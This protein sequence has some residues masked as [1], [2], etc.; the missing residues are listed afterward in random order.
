M[1]F[2]NIKSSLI[3]ACACLSLSV[4][5]SAALPPPPTA[6]GV[7]QT[8]D[9]AWSGGI[10]NT[11]SATG[12]I[13]LD[14]GWFT[15]GGHSVLLPST[16]VP[17]LSLTVSG[18]SAGNGT[19]GIAD[20]TIILL[21]LTPP[22]SSLTTNLVGQAGFTNF[23]LY[24][25]TNGVPYT[26]GAFQLTT[27]YNVA[28][29]AMSLTTFILHVDPPAAVAAG[30][31]AETAPV[32]FV[33]DIGSIGSAI[34]SSTPTALGLR[35]SSFNTSRTGISVFGQRLNRLRNIQDG[36]SNTI[37]F[38]ERSNNTS[39]AQDGTS[40]TIVVGEGDGPEVSKKSS[41]STK[42]VLP[43]SVNIAESTRWEVYTSFDYSYLDMDADED[44]EGLRSNTY[45]TGI[46]AEYALTPYLTF[47]LGTSYTTSDVKGGGNSGNTDVEGF[48]FVG[49]ASAFWNNF[50]ADLLYGATFLQNDIDRDTGLGKTAHANPNTVVQSVNFNT[51]YNFTFG[52]L[53]TG[54]YAGI[55]YAY[56]D[57]DGYTEHGGGTANT[58][59]SGQTNNSL[60]TRLGWQASY[61]IVKPWGKITPQINAG[62]ERE[63][64][65]SAEDVTVGLVQSPFY[66]VQGN[67]I[68]SA[69]GS[70]SSTVT[71]PGRA[72]DYMTAGAALMVEIGTRFN[73]ILDYQGA[74]FA[75]GFT[76]HTA[77]IKIGYKF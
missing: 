42:N 19:F 38:Q 52:Q 27:N 4:S 13:T 75:E 36:T 73:V 77:G 15:A 61:N 25:F 74:F 46:G 60:L 3:T 70:F 2:P 44:F 63:N 5:A 45:S 64:L 40:N 68:R 7:F 54:P 16:L 56:S 29:D 12:S 35:Q 66:R 57:V 22:L 9:L 14:T 6:T 51:G 8:Y 37:N 34:S 18:A 32:L 67:S 76:A 71:S 49:Y 41:K 47:G 30:A 33:T 43:P 24:T 11:A 26:T 59:V 72:Q 58:K 50:Y 1:I 28:G 21:D 10:A 31:A 55:D 62:W 69:G 17:A 39:N 23:G 20:F 65:N 53:V 48:T